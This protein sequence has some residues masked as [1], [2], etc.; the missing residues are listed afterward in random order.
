MLE[1]KYI[2][3]IDSQYRTLF[4]LP[5]GGRIRITH[6][7]GEQVERVCRY[8]GEY[9]AH[10]GS[11][12]YH[13]C[14]FAE[15][16]EQCGSRYE[17]LDYITEPEFY[18][19]RY[20]TPAKDPVRPP[21][22]IID[23]TPAYCFAFSP[24]GEK[25]KRFCIFERLPGDQNHTFRVGENMR[26]GGSLKEIRP[27]DWGFNVAKIKAVTGRKPKSRQEQER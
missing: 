24:K 9:H 17:P 6:S 21:Y 20:L 1:K 10:I 11:N 25:G 13:I 15:R 22:F 7:D 18:P 16:M 27:Q 4:H 5:D 3:F 23:E 12:D 2:R 8:L 26:W 19:K 14:E